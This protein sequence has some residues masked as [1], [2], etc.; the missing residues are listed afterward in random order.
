MSEQDLNTAAA[1]VPLQMLW[2]VGASSVLQ[3]AYLLLLPILMA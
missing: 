2:T 1:V 3:T